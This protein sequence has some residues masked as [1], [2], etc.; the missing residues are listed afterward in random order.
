LLNGGD[1]IEFKRGIGFTVKSARNN[2]SNL[3]HSRAGQF[4]SEELGNGCCRISGCRAELDQPL[5]LGNLSLGVTLGIHRESGK[6]V[7]QF[8]EDRFR[9]TLILGRTGSGK[10]NHCQQLQREDIR[11]GAGVFILAEHEDDALYAVSCISDERIGDALLLDF[12]NPE[13]LPRMNP[14]DVPC[15]D[16]A[17]ASK[18]ISELMELLT[19]DC[20]YDWAGPR[21]ED[22]LRNAVGLILMKPV[23]GAHSIAEINQVY[24]DAEHVK[25]LLSSCTDRAIYDFWTKTCP[26]E[27]KSR[28]SGELFQWFLSKARRITDDYVL[29][30]VFGAGLSTVDMQDV[31]DNGKIL[32][33][34]VPESRIG[35]PAARTISRWLVLQLRDAIMNRR[36]SSDGWGGLNYGL[37]EGRSVAGNSL[38]PFFVYVDEFSKFANPDFEVLLAESRKQHVGCILST[39]T[40]SQ[41]R[42]LDGKTGQIGRLEEAIIGNVGT[43]IVYP[44]GAYDAEILSHQFDVDA[45]KL[46]RIER[47]RP[48]AR[49]CVDNLIARPGTLEVGRRPD[50]DNPSAARRMA[51]RMVDS[52]VWVEV[53]GAKNRGEFLKA[54]GTPVEEPSTSCRSNTEDPKPDSGNQSE[55]ASTT[56][57]SKHV[58]PHC[59]E[60]PTNGGLAPDELGGV[61]PYRLMRQEL[62]DLLMPQY[63]ICLPSDWKQALEDSMKRGFEDARECYVPFLGEQIESVAEQHMRVHAALTVADFVEMSLPASSSAEDFCFCI[64]EAARNGFD[65]AKEH[66]G[67][68]S[69]HQVLGTLPAAVIEAWGWINDPDI[70]QA[71][72]EVAIEYETWSWFNDLG[73]MNDEG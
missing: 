63:E 64:R 26:E 52:G 12:S 30:H 66:H 55:S 5:T 67:W 13:F 29:R 9:H 44:V 69:F 3:W 62:L 19:L 18:A 68:S 25:D 65:Y 53:D 1:Q 73:I 11:S 51:R 54:V 22:L 72:E 37:F 21:F 45:D 27:K 61:I 17:A 42:T 47:Y 60:S 32:I 23:P 20:P 2:E 16:P 4:E 41:T 10:S 34:Y 56:V 33:A 48:L 6:E 36:A 38:D 50:A 28:D 8:N 71:E 43:T 57:A 70:L 15:G 24:T 14:L 49:L 58:Q 59:D 46:K 31:V 35:T 7:F 40:L 39:Q